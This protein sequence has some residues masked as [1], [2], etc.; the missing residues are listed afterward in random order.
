MQ[1][2]YLGNEIVRETEYNLNRR[3][4]GNHKKVNKRCSRKYESCV[5]IF[6]IVLESCLQQWSYLI[7]FHIVSFLWV[8]YTEGNNEEGGE[9]YINTSSLW[10]HV[11]PSNA[12]GFNIFLA[13]LDPQ[14][15]L[16]PDGASELITDDGNRKR[17]K[18]DKISVGGR[19]K[20]YLLLCNP[21][22]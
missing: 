20:D 1:I 21:Y 22:G 2:Q 4:L 14:K 18:S 17:R 9:I 16:Q 10:N 11:F 6:P 19:L 8:Y 5:D 7:L 3:L 15:T 13:F 12:K